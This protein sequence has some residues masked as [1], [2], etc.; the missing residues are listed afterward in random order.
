MPKK[1]FQSVVSDKLNL[2]FAFFYGLDVKQKHKKSLLKELFGKTPRSY[3]YMKTFLMKSAEFGNFETYDAKKY[4]HTI[5]K[6]LRCNSISYNNEN[7]LKWYNIV[8]L[9]YGTVLSGTY[10]PADET[11]EICKREIASI[12]ETQRLCEYGKA[13]ERFIKLCIQ[14]NIINGNDKKGFKLIKNIFNAD[15]F[16]NKEKDNLYD[17][18]Y[19]L[20]H[21]TVLNPIGSFLA[22]RLENI[23]Q[24]R[25][26]R[27]AFIVKGITPETALSNE[28][29]FRCLK[30]IHEK[31]Y[32]FI[33]RK[34]YVPKEVFYKKTSPLYPEYPYVKS[35]CGTTFNIG[36]SAILIGETI[37]KDSIFENNISV[38]KRKYLVEYYID[39][40][41][42]YYLNEK[43]R[44]YKG[45]INIKLISGRI[46]EIESPYYPTP[47]KCNVY[48]AQ[49]DISYEENDEFC[50]WIRSFGEFA[51][52]VKGSNKIEEHKKHYPSIT[53]KINDVSFED[54]LCNP[55]NSLHFKP[56]TYRNEDIDLPPSNLEIFWLKYA[57]EKYSG[58]AESFMDENQ[59]CKLQELCKKYCKAQESSFN[60]FDM[61]DFF[62]DV[63]VFDIDRKYISLVKIFI[64]HIK[65]SRILEYS[66]I[67]DK[68][69]IEERILPYAIDYDL[70]EKTPKVM[71]YSLKEHRIIVFDLYS[72]GIKKGSRIRTAKLNENEKAYLSA[73]N[74]ELNILKGKIYSASKKQDR[75]EFDIK[76][77]NAHRK[78]CYNWIKAN[79]KNGTDESISRFLHYYKKIMDNFPKS[80]K[81][82]AENIFA[83]YYKLF[84]NN[85]ERFCDEQKKQG[86]A[87][88][89]DEEIFHKTNMLFLFYVSHKNS[90]S[91]QPKNEKEYI[92]MINYQ[93]RYQAATMKE[94]KVILKLKENVVL[95]IEI[96]DRIYEIFSSYNCIVETNPNET[97]FIVVY[98]KFNY[99]KIHSIVLALSD[100]IEVDSPKETKI[101]IAKRIK[102]MKI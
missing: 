50:E 13:S 63:P 93:I 66:H 95:T 57:L 76:N 15:V 29:V 86:V 5:P 98:E 78:N 4:S 16:S 85:M 7:S 6:D 91:K 42:T 73:A 75:Y 84:S 21:I 83:Y 55:Y 65:N 32:L 61:S 31:R 30:A 11:I 41:Y 2:K 69:E 100:I 8:Y 43:I 70:N 62:L 53:H 33:G 74:L 67:E 102:N 68:R 71:A 45:D 60:P 79:R 77:K 59:I 23:Y 34:K 39:Q 12:H 37:K 48:Q 101:L 36:K 94:R 40:R 18:V 52:I 38:E 97:M 1:T 81:N 64:E 44:H 20:S 87:P 22:T 54:A 26:R 82:L 96:L 3:E 72:F 88:V 56:K 17:F 80:K 51:K 9:N 35:I 99:R 47:L 27:K 46:K 10:S 89:S 49:H 92:D 28:G 19:L 14:R 25:K 90:L 24:I 58:L